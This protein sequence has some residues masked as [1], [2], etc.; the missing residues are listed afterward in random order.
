MCMYMYVCVCI[1]I[2]MY[3]YIYIYIYIYTYT[4]T[5]TYTYIRINM[6]VLAATMISVFSS[7]EYL[8]R[9]ACR[10]LAEIVSFQRKIT[11]KC[12]G[13]LQKQQICATTV[14]NKQHPSS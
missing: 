12:C 13:D 1:Y 4:Y 6:I 2:Y 14:Q 10:K 11:N 3:M 7:T 5:Y 9:H 8:L